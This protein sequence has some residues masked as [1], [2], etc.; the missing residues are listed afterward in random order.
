VFIVIIISIFTAFLPY[1]YMMAF[2]QD[3]EGSDGA[4]PVDRT[5]PEEPS[6]GAGPTS[7][8]S[9]DEEESSEDTMTLDNEQEEELEQLTLD[10]ID[11]E[12]LAVV[13][14]T[15]DVDGAGGDGTAAKQV[16]CVENN[17]GQKFSY[18]YLKPDENCLERLNVEDPPLCRKP[19]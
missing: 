1:S 16:V 19:C 9:L 17:Q 3:D 18:E 4:E 11:S 12:G 13:N 6:N 8:G 7:G 15:A 5:G 10:M 2:A 14:D